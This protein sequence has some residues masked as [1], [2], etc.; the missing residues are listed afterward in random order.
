MKNYKNF[1]FKERKRYEESFVENNSGL[2]QE[3]SGAGSVFNI[4]QTPLNKRA[5]LGT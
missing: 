2:I 5:G 1:S 4:S 3:I